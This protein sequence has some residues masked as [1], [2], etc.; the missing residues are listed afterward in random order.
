MKR[1]F[2]IVVL[3][4]CLSL[5]VAHQP[6]IV[7][8]KAISPGT[9]VLIGNPEISKAYYGELNE[10]PNFFKI[11]SRIYY[12]LYVNILVPDNENSRTDFIVEVFGPEG[13]HVLNGSDFEW[14][15]FYEEYGKDYYLMGPELELDHSVDGIYFIKV[16]NPDNLGKYALAVGKKEHF[17]WKDGLASL[18]ALPKIKHYWFE[19]SWMSGFNNIFG[20]VFLIL[21]CGAI[22]VVFYAFKLIDK[23]QKGKRKK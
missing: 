10:Y 4:L 13:Y 21:V 7:F 19:K 11:E 3:V 9:P 20:Y 14:I 15:Q 6:R 12:D 17:T 18:I 2:G 22:A 1:L 16:S 23:E 5:V 8:D